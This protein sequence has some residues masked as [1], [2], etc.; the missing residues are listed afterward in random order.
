MGV[1]FD[2]AEGMLRTL[3]DKR[4]IEATIGR[5]EP[6]LGHKCLRVFCVH[7]KD[8]RRVPLMMGTFPVLPCWIDSVLKRMQCESRNILK[9]GTLDRKRK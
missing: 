7:K 1:N 3:L 6:E 4:G 2:G 8:V 5:L 9:F